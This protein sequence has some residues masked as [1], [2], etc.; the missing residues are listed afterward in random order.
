M[1]LSLAG[2]DVVRF[3]PS[4]VVS[5]AQLDEAVSVLGQVLAEGVATPT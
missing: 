4:F 5:P 1:L 3:A 2:A